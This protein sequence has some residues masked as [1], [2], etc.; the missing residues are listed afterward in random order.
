MQEPFQSEAGP[1]LDRPA[2]QPPT[3]AD[4]RTRSPAGASARRLL[5]R[6]APFVGLA[7]FALALWVL[8]DWLAEQRSG[9]VAAALSRIPMAALAGAAALTLANYVVLTGYDLLAMRYVGR[10]LPLASVA[11]TAFVANALGNNF[12]NTLITG[13]AVRYWSYTSAGL[14]GP[15]IARVVVFCSASFWLGYLLVGGL[16]FAIS[17]LVLP[18]GVRWAGPTTRTLGLACLLLL[19]TYVAVTLVAGFQRRRLS[20]GTWALHPPSPALTLGQL[21]VGVFDVCLMAAVFYALLP[22]G[23]ATLVEC[24]AVVLVALVAG[25]LSLVPGGLGVFES[26]VVLMFG[27]RLPAASLA[28]ALLAYRAVYFLAPLLVAV[29]LLGARAGAGFVQAFASARRG[30][31][32]P[33][34]RT[35]VMLAPDLLAAAVF[36]AG[37]LLLLSGSLPAAAGRLQALGAL[38][39]LPLIEASHFLASAIGAAL[40][41]LAHALQRRLDGAWH[42]A[43]LLLAAATVLSL[44]K[45]WDYEQAVVLAAVAAILVS[46]HGQFRRKSSLFAVPFSAGWFTAAAI[47]LL[48]AGWLVYFAYAHGP[49]LD[50]PW[51][52]FA[53]HAEAARSLRGAVGAAMLTALAGLHWL[54]RPAPPPLAPPTAAE[55][56]RAQA[57]AQRSPATY[58]NLVLRGDKAIMFDDARD[59]FLMYGRSGR[60]WV[61]MGDPVG[62]PAGTRELL[63]RF[64]DLCDRF[65]G[66]CVFFEVREQR[67]GDYAELGLVLTP[68]GEQARV[69]LARFSLDGPAHRELRHARARLLK[70][71]CRFEIVPA[72]GVPALLPDLADVSRAWL[73]EKA[74]HEKGF[75]NASFDAGYLANF[76]VALVRREERVVAFA[77]L[78]LGA[79]QEELSID[80]MRRLPSAPHGTMDFLF[81]ELLL[82]G[83]S[84]GY[85][86]FDFGMAP[87]SGLDKREA[88]PL[89]S[90]VAT[91]LYR[92]GEHFYNFEGLRRYKAKFDPVWT[93]LYLA[94]PGGVALPA[95]LVDV[96]AL[97]AGSLPGILTRYGGRERRRPA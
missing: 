52:V 60:S 12:G 10:R 82:W 4:S 41:L 91:L 57:I 42:L 96:T 73:A 95:I 87:L 46:A 49:E 85:R 97:V 9:A 68:V 2:L 50:Q 23:D 28:A 24:M 43:V 58:A 66:W 7:A 70:Q 64:R 93:P 29:A 8:Q 84:Q 32:S 34:A 88:H 48:A 22:A 38:L 25:N 67:R 27:G 80:L 20:F 78:W 35:L 65:D 75:S 11:T 19:A 59:T 36:L 26:V 37:A 61:A 6:A 15:D 39:E 71:G 94:S 13:A 81:C 44:A 62:T 76:P 14:S 45:G 16:L 1:V 89:W 3:A 77:N 86:W 74:T 33:G 53:L 17:P 47:V 56:E 51:W 30:R 55:M 69:E 72:A 92:H 90:R 21:T 18:A 79:G 5:R 40:L 83:Q 63:W 54:L 31:A